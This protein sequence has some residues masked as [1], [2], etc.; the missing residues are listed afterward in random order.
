MK[1][2]LC[3]IGKN[4]N[5]YIREFVEHYQK[6]GIDTIFLYDNNNI[7]GENFEEVI[8]DY[9]NDDFVKIINFRGK[10]ICQL[11]AY[12]DCYDNYA[13]D[14][15]WICYFDCDEFLEL[16]KYNNIKEYLSDKSIS[17]YDMVHINWMIYG[18]NNLIGNEYS[19]DRSLVNRFKNPLP[20][21]IC[22]FGWCYKGPENNHIKTIVKTK[23]NVDWLHSWN[24]HTPKCDLRCCS[25]NGTEIDGNSP[26]TPYN[27]ECAYLKHYISKT[28]LEWVE[29]M[30][31]G[32]CDQAD[33]TAKKNLSLDR[34]FKINYLTY[35]KVNALNGKLE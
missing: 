11:E 31:R 17:K 29:K 14:Y 6:I 9:V 21:D 30:K 8:G 2:C 10:K 28:I 26:W 1:V 12:Q 15:E 3:C 19:Y 13:N 34:F 24:P 22:G 18:D 5:Q 35:K 7:D 20:Y 33:S 4:E 32:Y 16:T 23:K 27:F 25:N